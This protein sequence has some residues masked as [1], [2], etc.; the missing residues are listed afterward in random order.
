M[1]ITVIVSTYNN[2]EWLEKVLWGYSAQ[3]Y[4]DFEMIVADDGS[5]DE[6]RQCI[7][8]IRANTGLELN[9]VWHEDLGFRKTIILNRAVTEARTDYILFTDGDCVPRRDF[10][11]VHSRF[12]KPGFFLSGGYFRLPLEL[13]CSISREDITSGRAFNARWLYSH[14]VTKN[15]R[16]VK[17]ILPDWG[18]RFCNRF[19][20]TLPTFKG[21]NASCWKAD[22]LKVNGFDE[23]MQWGGEDREFGERLMNA[24]IRPRQIRYSAACVHLDHKRDYIPDTSDINATIRSETFKNKSKWTPYGIVKENPK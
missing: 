8:M 20:T 5:T 19:T 15:P 7:D 22:I 3:D 2:P 10:I 21:C 6:T 23:R 9:H 17:F 14:G 13:S 4:P 1:R 16:L 12:A 24:G 11:S 18:A